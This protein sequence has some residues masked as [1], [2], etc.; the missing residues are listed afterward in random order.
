MT[1]LRPK[2]V[3]VVRRDLNMRKGK[4]AA[5]SGHAASAWMLDGFIV[6]DTELKV[7]LTPL[8]RDW[9]DPNSGNQAKIVVGCDSEVEL[10]QLLANAALA[11]VVTH[12]ITDSGRTEFHGIPTVTCAAFGPDLPWK[13]DP[14]TGHLKLL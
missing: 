13:L 7:P 6:G 2:M 5:Q 1:D 3:I 4:I 8:Y 9:L 14:V 11:G 10:D 12:K